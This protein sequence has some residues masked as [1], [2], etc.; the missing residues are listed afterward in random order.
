LE[1]AGVREGL[2]RREDAATA[3]AGAVD[4]VESFVLRE[5][6]RRVAGALAAEGVGGW[7]RGKENK[8][9]TAMLESSNVLHEMQW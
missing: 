3:G 2:E 6:D 1:A 9:T 8:A 7:V 4:S 5:D